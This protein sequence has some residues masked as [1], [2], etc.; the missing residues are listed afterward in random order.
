V[1][2]R[3]LEQGRI[4]PKMGIR[5]L[6]VATIL[7]G[8]VLVFHNLEVKSLR[9]D[10]IVQALVSGLPIPRILVDV[11]QVR[12]QPPLYWVLLHFFS[13]LGTT[14]FAVRFLSALFGVVN[15]AL[16]YRLAACMYG[17]REGLVAAFLLAISPLHLKYAQDARMYSAMVCFPTLS[18]YWL[19][20]ALAESKREHWAGFV[21]GAVLGLWTHAYAGFVFVA[22][23]AFGSL[24]LLHDA[25]RARGGGVQSAARSTR[26]RGF[27]TSVGIAFVAWVPVLISLRR[28]AERADLDLGLDEHL[29]RLPRSL[30]DLA[31]LGQEYLGGSA[32][33]LAVCGLLAVAGLVSSWVGHKREMAPLGL[34]VA[35]L[36]GGLYIVQSNRGF[37]TVR[38]AIYLLP[39]LLV[40]VARGVRTLGGLVASLVR[41]SRARRLRGAIGATTAIGILTVIG[42]LTGVSIRAHYSAENENFRALASFLEQEIHPDDL[43]LTIVPLCEAHAEDRNAFTWYYD[44]RH[45]NLRRANLSL[46]ELQGMVFEYPRTWVV[47]R[48][49]GARQLSA[50]AG[51]W[52]E[53]RFEQIPFVDFDIYL[54]GE[55]SHTWQAYRRGLDLVAEG[56][57]LRA[58]GLL[59][60]AAFTYR[61]AA[62]AASDLFD[63]RLALAQVY[64]EM[65]MPAEAAAE[66]RRVIDLQPE[67][68]A[69][70][71]GL[72]LVYDLLGEF[73]EA[74]AMRGLSE[75]PPSEDW[76]ARRVRQTRAREH[77]ERGSASQEQGELDAAIAEYQTAI[78]LDDH[79]AGAHVRLGDAWRQR[80][81]WSDALEEYVAALECRPELGQEVWFRI[82]L[83]NAFRE[84]GLVDEAIRSYQQVLEL[85]PE[86]AIAKKW[87]EE[88]C[89]QR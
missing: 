4:V 22:E 17:W 58:D 21:V 31:E 35:V 30:G 72:A 50:S 60:E 65:S 73:E 64:Q 29:S 14:E 49:W 3:Y 59:E 36:A 15:I 63:A 16:I 79:L 62:E 9:F 55:S 8:A 68:Q 54:M 66:Y 77:F 88:L 25:V 40:A 27:V 33:L 51:A 44:D 56:N 70:Y 26:L 18:L 46:P 1:N 2:Q 85:K 24:W 82:R 74:E 48:H 39:L 67:S 75:A 83:A 81:Q 57:R 89:R 61:E 12:G 34:S 13:P 19:Y 45:Q 78:E 80:E 23:I 76:A 69:H 47:G 84:T 52:V 53:G 37:F 41:S 10:E 11:A 28:L 42:M 7:L 6:L 5:W 86:H 38:Y 43:L 20:R 87:V 71:L 32:E